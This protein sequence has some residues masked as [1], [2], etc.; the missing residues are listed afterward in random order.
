MKSLTPG[1]WVDGVTAALAA[2]ALGSAVVVQA[3]LGT[4]EGSLSVVATNLAYPLGDVLLLSLIVG[5]FT[6]TRWRPGRVWLLLGAS[7]AVSALADSVY[8][9]A[10]ATGTYREGTLLD[11]AWPAGLLLIACAGWQDTGRER[12]VDVAGRTFLAAPA[13]CG[14]IAVGVLVVDHFQRLN[15]LAIVLATL[16]LAGV[17]ARLAVT[18][19]ENRQLL[20]RA[21]DEAVTDELTALGN[22][23]R[24]IADLDEVL[25][26]ATR[27]R[28]WLLAIYDLDG[29]KAYNDAFGHPAG[30]ALL[31]RLGRKMDAVPGPGGGVYRLGGDEFCLLAPLAGDHAGRLLDLSLEALSE[32]GEGFDVTSSF[33]AVILPEEANEGIEALRKADERLYVQKRGKQSSRNRPREVLLQALYE[34]EPDLHHHVHDV[35]AVAV[36]VGALLGLSSDEL[37]ELQHAAMLH[38]IGKI[39]IPDQI[40]HKPG[41]L[42]DEEWA[43]VK[44]HTIVG[45]RILGA[46]P[47]LRSIGRIVRASHERW[48][49][50]GYP[51]GLAGTE[52]PLAARIVFACDAFA[53][54]TANRTYREALS[55]ADALA[56]LEREAGTQFDADVVRVL[57]AVVRARTHV[58]AA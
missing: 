19:R 40:L 2:G 47:A 11:A 50:A 41:R 20:R 45:E 44:R 36:D 26:V 33:G 48:D 53:A 13:A 8:L 12:A 51:D 24:L 4:V 22:R 21:S 39:A 7:L 49:G 3:V 54:M 10:T 30:D 17:L 38:D 9:Y 57:V 31:I 16:T 46:S 34:R 37:D 52:I 14:A 35:A 1:V 56:E 55:E 6:L 15:L 25:A 5:A 27:E 42:D 43:F 28:P 58:A 18:F 29:F 23:R 32:Q